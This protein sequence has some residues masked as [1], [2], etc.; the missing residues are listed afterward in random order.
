MSRMHLGW[1]GLPLVLALLAGAPSAHEVRPAYLELSQIDEDTYDLLW[2]VPAR[3]EQALGLHLRL[4]DGIRIVTP[5]VATATAGSY[6][7]RS[8]IFRPGGLVGCEIHVEGLATTLT[9]ALVRVQRLDGSTQV[10]RLTPALPSFVVEAQPGA[11][12]VVRVY[13]SLGIEHILLG[14]DHLLF[15]LALLLLVSGWRRLVA[16]ITAFSVSHTVT[17]T[18]ASLGYVRVPGPPVEAVI[19]LSI[20]FVAAEIL[21]RREGRPGLAERWPWSV[22][23]TF[24]LLHGLGFA[25]ALHEVGLPENDIP[26]ALACFSAGV[27]LGQLAFVAVVLGFLAAGA[28]ALAALRLRDPSRSPSA[29]ALETASAHAI[30]GIACYWLI[31]RTAGFLG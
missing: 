19:A 18:L 5:P 14:V 29:A 6:L 20:A 27:E 9:D 10:A 22:S 16:T 15:L 11:L 2:K 7:E 21:R 28:R 24:G 1:L 12:D 26:L 23:F 31:E 25:G 13:L 30:G 3:G 4:P 8:R 17:L